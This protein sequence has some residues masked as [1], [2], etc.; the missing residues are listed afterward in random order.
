MKKYAIRG[1]YLIHPQTNKK[2]EE[3]GTK[4][5]RIY[6]LMVSKFQKTGAY[7]AWI[8]LWIGTYRETI[9]P[10]E[11]SWILKIASNIFKSISFIS[12]FFLVRGQL[13]VKKTWNW[14]VKETNQKWMY[15]HKRWKRRSTERYSPWN[16]LLFSSKLFWQL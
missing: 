8:I 13:D 12:F 10:K 4:I 9:W 15:L 3:S 14:I 16:Y 5:Q 1:E 11:Y 2:L 6:H 7:Y